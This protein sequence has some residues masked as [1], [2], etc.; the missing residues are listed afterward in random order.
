M[1]SVLAWGLRGATGA[2][3]YPFQKP[4]GANL[5]AIV[6]NTISDFVQDKNAVGEGALHLS[7]VQ[8]THVASTPDA[9][10]S[11]VNTVQS[12]LEGNKVDFSASLSASVHIERQEAEDVFVVIKEYFIQFKK[13]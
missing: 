6:Y 4:V 9:V 8:I 11:M 13:V 7:R 1:Q 2:D 10:I 12:Y 3:V 5:P